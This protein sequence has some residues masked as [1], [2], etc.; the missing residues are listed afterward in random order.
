LF[1]LPILQGIAIGITL[2]IAIF[3]LAYICTPCALPKIHKTEIIEE[4]TPS[5]DWNDSL[6]GP[7]YYEGD[8]PQAAAGG[9]QIKETVQQ[10]RQEDD[11]DDVASRGYYDDRA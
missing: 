6:D 4:L 10:V 1:D 3:I 5:E 2:A 7:I 8:D 11:F 9:I